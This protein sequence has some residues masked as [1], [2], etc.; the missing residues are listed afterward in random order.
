[1]MSTSVTSL[2]GHT[3]LDLPTNEIATAFFEMDQNG[4][5][6]LKFKSVAFAA[7]FIDLALRE[8]VFGLQLS[9]SYAAA[10]RKDEAN[11]NPSGD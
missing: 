10:K 9:L 1:M 4:D 11:E 6:V 2:E 7:N 8:D 5:V 3:L